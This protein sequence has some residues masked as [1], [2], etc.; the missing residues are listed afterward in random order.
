MTQPGGSY[1]HLRRISAPTSDTSGPLQ[2]ERKSSLVP[3]EGGEFKGHVSIDA[4][5]CV[6]FIFEPGGNAYV[7]VGSAAR[8]DSAPR[9]TSWE[10]AQQAA[11]RR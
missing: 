2:P 8:G 1:G 11:G 9:E 7:G 3:Q 10:R 6:A 4:D 5:T